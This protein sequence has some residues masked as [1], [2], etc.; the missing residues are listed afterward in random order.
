LLERGEGNCAAR[1]NGQD[2]GN[3]G[4]A[5]LDGLGCLEEQPCSL[6]R[7]CLRPGGECFGGCLD[8][9]LRFRSATCSNAGIQAAIVRAEDVK[10]LVIFSRAPF[11]T[12]KVPIFLDD[13][14][15]AYVT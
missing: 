12:C 2:V 9:Q 10:Q 5:A 15:F 6:G 13:V 8:R 4:A 1:L 14:R 11:T 7:S 3:L